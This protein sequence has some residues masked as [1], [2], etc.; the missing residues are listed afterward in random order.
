MSG[1]APTR[2]CVGVQQWTVLV[3]VDGL[4][5]SADMGLDHTVENKGS[6]HKQGKAYIKE[7]NVDQ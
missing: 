3:G 4:G 2:L 1:L 7:K 6:V 5:R